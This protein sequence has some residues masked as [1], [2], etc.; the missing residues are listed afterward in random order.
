MNFNKFNKYVHPSIPDKY[1]KEFKYEINRIGIYRVKIIAAIL[2]MIELMMLILTFVIEREK[3]FYTPR[4]YYV[5]MYAIMLLFGIGY[6]IIFIKLGKHKKNKEKNIF[7]FFYLFTI[8]VLLW[9]AIISLLDQ[10]TYGQIT[11]YFIAIIAVGLIS[12][13]EPMPLLLIYFFAQIIFIIFLPYFQKSN[14]ILFGNSVNSSIMIIV[15]WIIQML[16]Y[17]RKVDDFINKKIIEEKNDEL[18]KLYDELMK[19]N[20]EL[21]FLAQK[22]GLTGLYNRLMFDRLLKIKWEQCLRNSRLLTLIMIDIDF[23]KAF[24][25]C[26]GHQAG[27]DCLKKIAKALYDFPINSSSFVAR[28]GGEEFVIVMNDINKENAFLIAEK[29]RKSI[30]L[31]EIPHGLSSISEHVTISL[32]VCT[33]IPSDKKSIDKF[34]KDTDIALYKAKE[35]RNKVIVC[36]TVV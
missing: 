16:L 9:N 11:A 20:K 23:F 2:I 19:A 30:N 12:I 29:I 35:S 24:N 6:L 5:I 17:K 26:Y 34:F 22:D 31:L 7:F 18:K 32:G 10:I 21:E 8:F 13:F 1:Q 36:E 14:S 28:Y 25:D 33:T 3:S 15:S 27:D 4:I